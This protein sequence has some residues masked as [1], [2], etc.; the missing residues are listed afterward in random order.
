MRVLVT[1][2]AGFI[3]SHVAVALA[4]AGHDVLMLD[5]FHPAAHRSAPEPP[6]GL[7]LVVGDVRDAETVERAVRGVDAVVHQA[8]MV[9]MGVDLADLPEYVGCNDLGTAVL[10]AAMA[11][12]EIGR[13]SCRERV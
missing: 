13:A 3:G 9:G 7:P 12:A 11:R 5:S 4:S 10:L 8:A 2:G 1:G 6:G